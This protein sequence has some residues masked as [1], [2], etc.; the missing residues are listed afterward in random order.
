VTSN[1]S[2]KYVFATQDDDGMTYKE[3]LKQG[4]VNALQTAFPEKMG[5]PAGMIVV[6]FQHT[7]LALLSWD[8]YQLHLQ[9]KITDTEW[10]GYLCIYLEND[11]ESESIAAKTL[12]GMAEEKARSLHSI[13]V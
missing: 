5:Y 12:I 8:M 11:G 4:F 10:W 3:A 2:L 7:Y 13:K 9:K 6:V 1:A